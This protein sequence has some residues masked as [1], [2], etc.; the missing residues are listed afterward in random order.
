MDVGVTSQRLG[1]VQ[2]GIE[3]AADD[4]R[5]SLGL[6]PAAA[7]IVALDTPRLLADLAASGVRVQALD[8]SGGGSFG[9]NSHPQSQNAPFQPASGDHESRE[10][11]A[12]A[13]VTRGPRASDRYA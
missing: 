4:L 13:T 10:L 3:G 1:S 12:P 6:S 2:I 9:N 5:V 8:V 11:A 7:A